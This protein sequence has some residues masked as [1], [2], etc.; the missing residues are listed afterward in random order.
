MAV[1]YLGAMEQFDGV[2]KNARDPQL[3]ALAEGLKL[4]T[5]AIRSDLSKI[6]REVGSVKSEVGTVRNRVQSL[7]N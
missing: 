5:Q 2:V 1:G 4:L 3:V 7:R 6:E